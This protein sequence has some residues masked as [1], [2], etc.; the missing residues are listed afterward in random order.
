MPYSY[1]ASKDP[2]MNPTGPLNASKKTDEKD[3][4]K[5]ENG[6][7]NK[8]KKRT[9]QINLSYFK[10][11][12]NGG[13]GAEKEDT[14]THVGDDTTNTVSTDEASTFRNHTQH[15]QQHYRYVQESFWV[16][17]AVVFAFAMTTL[18]VG[19]VYVLVDG[20]RA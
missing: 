9:F 8:L 20:M 4:K 6:K 10:D 16:F 18:I 13:L 2:I 5:T 11:A 14:H 12:S 15:S 3:K 17:W 1:L 7:N 19:S